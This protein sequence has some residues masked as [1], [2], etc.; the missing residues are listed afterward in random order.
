M[1]EVTS[2]RLDKYLKATRLIK[3]RTVAKDVSEQGRIMVNGRT[4]KPA[5]D[6]KIGDHITLEFGRKTLTVE[7]TDVSETAAKQDASLMYRVIEEK[8]KPVE[9]HPI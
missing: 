8:L 2:V 1:C 7:V 3:R 4:A 6:V 9:D 5:T